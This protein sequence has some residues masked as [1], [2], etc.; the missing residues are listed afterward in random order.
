M[1]RLT[2]AVD[3]VKDSHKIDLDIN[4]ECALETMGHFPS[5]FVVSFEHSI[6]IFDLLFV[7]RWEKT[8]LYK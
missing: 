5:F 7:V 4:R 1:N 3:S 8:N 2:D 6:S